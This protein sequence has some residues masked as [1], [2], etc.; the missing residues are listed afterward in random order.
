MVCLREPRDA[1]GDEAL[2][3]PVSRILRIEGG[4]PKEVFFT[5]FV[6]ECACHQGVLKTL[7]FLLFF[8]FLGVFSL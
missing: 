5:V 4:S 6:C 3:I 7:L 2:T 8:D 1:F